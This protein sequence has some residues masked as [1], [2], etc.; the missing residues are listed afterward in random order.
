MSRECWGLKGWRMEK[1]L[2]CNYFDKLRI[3]QN[4]SNRW[5]RFWSRGIAVLFIGHIPTHQERAKR[6]PC[7]RR[8]SFWVLGS[9][10]IPLASPLYPFLVNI[11]EQLLNWGFGILFMWIKSPVPFY[12]SNPYH[13]NQKPHAYNALVFFRGLS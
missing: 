6:L 4:T 5:S 7:E 9:I 11:F 8:S 13:L 1:I 2:P 12:P 3:Y 10:N